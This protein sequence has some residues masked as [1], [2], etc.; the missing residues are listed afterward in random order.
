MAIIIT[1]GDMVAGRHQSGSVAKTLHLRVN[2]H[3]S[4]R[5]LTEYCGL[6]QPVNTPL[7][8]QLLQSNH[9][10]NKDKPSNSSQTVL[11]TVGLMIKHMKF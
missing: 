1:M 3:K 2:K 10:A 11:L 6:L 8:K 9:N 7:V 4:E 5:E